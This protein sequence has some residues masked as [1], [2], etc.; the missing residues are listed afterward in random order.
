MR[1]QL[2]QLQTV[3]SAIAGILNNADGKVHS[4]VV[5]YPALLRIRQI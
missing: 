5:L 4:T 1:H 3:V 2:E